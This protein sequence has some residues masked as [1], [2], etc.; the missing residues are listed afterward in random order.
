MIKNENSHNPIPQ[1]KYKPATRYNDI[2]YT[3]GMTPR[4]EGVLI[5]TGKV[6]NKKPIIIYKK[7]GEQATFNA[8]TAT[9]SLLNKNETIEEVILLK[10]YINTDNNFRDH[11]NI[12]DFSSDYLYKV[13]GTPFLGS[14]VTIGVSSLPG[15]APVEIHIISAV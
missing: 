2:I 5:Q 8:L 9:K 3:S 7:S 15:N 10:V 1:G 13:T 14:R 12:A 4:K 6:T 11:S